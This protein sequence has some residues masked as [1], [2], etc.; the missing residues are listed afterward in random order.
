MKLTEK[1][2]EKYKK[3]FIEKYEEKYEELIIVGEK[4]RIMGIIEKAMEAELEK[5]SDIDVMERKHKIA[6]T[7]NVMEYVDKNRDEGR[8][9][10]DEYYSLTEEER[11]EWNYKYEIPEFFSKLKITE[12]VDEL[13][14]GCGIDC[15]T[16]EECEELYTMAQESFDEVCEYYTINGHI[17]IES[18][19]EFYEDLI[20]NFNVRIQERFG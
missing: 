3:K 14:D 2:I 1:E 17:Y 20:I 15:Q 10:E 9:T 4:K 13:L 16:E 11:E 12:M 5:L 18:W 19:G 8:L 7:K 6:F